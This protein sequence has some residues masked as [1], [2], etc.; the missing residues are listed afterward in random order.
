VCDLYILAL[1]SKTWLNEKITEKKKGSREKRLPNRK[2]E[3]G[4]G[5]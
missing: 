2:G 4:E 5:P 1:L 3:R